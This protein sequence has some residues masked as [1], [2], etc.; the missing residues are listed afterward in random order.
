MMSSPDTVTD[1]QT[2]KT[3]PKRGRRVL[4]AAIVALVGAFVVLVAGVI[5]MHGEN[6]NFRGTI[7]QLKPLPDD[8]TEGDNKVRMSK[9]LAQHGN[10]G[11]GRYV[12]LSRTKRAHCE[13]IRIPLC[14][15]MPYNSVQFPN[16]LKHQTQEEAML[17]ASELVPLVKA[18]CSSSMESFL[19]SVLAPPCNGT[20]KPIPPCKG[21][22]KRA[23][24]T[25][26]NQLKKFQI[27][28]DPAMRCKHLPK[29][30][31]SSC[32]NGSW[33]KTE[34]TP[35]PATGCRPITHQCNRYSPPPWRS[36]F[37][38]YF[39][40]VN[41]KEAS[42]SFQKFEDI[43]Q[44]ASKDCSSVLAHF[45]CRLHAPPCRDTKHPL[46]PCRELCLE[47][48]SE[49]RRAIR[50]VTKTKSFQWP[51]DLKCRN[52]PRKD[53]ASCYSGP[54]DGGDTIMPQNGKCQVISIP[55]CKN[56]PYNMT[57]FPNFFRHMTQQEASLEVHQF[58]PLVKVNCS[59]DLAF[60]LCSLYAP[61]C[62]ALDRP[63]LPCRALCLRVRRGCLPL[64][65]KFG[66]QWPDSMKCDR[67]PKGGEDE[68]CI[69]TPN[70][71]EV[72]TPPPLPTKAG[73]CEPL[74]VSTCSGLHYSTTWVPN[75]FQHQT[76]DQAARGINKYNP[77]L[78]TNC[79]A[80]L[81]LFL[82]SLYAPNCS[83]YTYNIPCKEL[84]SRVKKR[85]VPRMRELGI[86]WPVSCSKFPRKAEEPGCVGGPPSP[87]V[88]KAT[89]LKDGQCEALAIPM[90][91]A[92]HYNMTLF[93]NF[94]NHETQKEAATEIK[95]FLPLVRYGCSPEMSLFLCSLYAPP[96]SV[97]RRP[98]KEL[99]KR[100][101]RSCLPVLKEFGIPWPQRMACDKFPATE[102]A[103]NC[104]GAQLSVPPTA[105]LTTQS[106]KR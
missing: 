98:C 103:S 61:L 62:S 51:S 76:Q 78:K 88:T 21:L 101:Q 74:S 47:V 66:F 11:K 38:N 93:P 7:A 90:C 9:P 17:V 43:F 70:P 72:T 46:P 83:P 84:C 20:Q 1:P 29:E 10:M 53:E 75:Y 104:I 25:C 87:P 49:C 60:F 54:S 102:E 4:I 6:R 5:L 36:Q 26:K 92:M 31:V 14:K 40:H 91:G 3:E 32:F 73:T 39:G 56:V 23:T 59:Q 8:V 22:C 2:S 37:P 30:G 33:P 13:P 57:V 16:L 99:C 89:P 15:N 97:P 65:L 96:C 95:S 52:F 85:C 68:V 64:L 105:S 42:V 18:G 79:S 100:V 106:G 27:M 71:V 86:K 94:F 63:P 12:R 45:L 28:S 81:T 48:K 24:K 35:R 58:S 82:C 19:C 77:I 67:F 44:V 34:N 55:L 41:D 50:N 80:E 69:D